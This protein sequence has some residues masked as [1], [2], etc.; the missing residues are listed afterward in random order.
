MIKTVEI[1]KPTGEQFLEVGQ[2]LLDG[3]EKETEVKVSKISVFND[4]ITVEFSDGNKNVFKG[5]P[6]TLVITKA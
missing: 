6:F 4:K 5:Y 2:F 1:T 3:K